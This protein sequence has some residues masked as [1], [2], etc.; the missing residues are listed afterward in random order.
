MDFERCSR[1]KNVTRRHFLYHKSYIA[2]LDN[3]RCGTSVL[4]H[5]KNFTT[6]APKI[7]NVQLTS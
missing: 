1:T 2:F 5:I 4:W 7:E 6:A 3:L